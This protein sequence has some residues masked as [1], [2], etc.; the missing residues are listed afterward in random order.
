MTGAEF[1]ALMKKQRSR[2]KRSDP[3]KR[4]ADGMVFDSIAEMT[5]YRELRYSRDSGLVKWFIRQP[6]F[7]LAGAKYHADFLIVWPDG[8]I[9]VEDVKGKYSGRF[10][11]EALRTFSRNRKQVMQLYGIDVELVER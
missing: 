10:R 3:A 9:S 11:S 1:K 4:T 5:R 7:D 6:R 8:S 2:Y